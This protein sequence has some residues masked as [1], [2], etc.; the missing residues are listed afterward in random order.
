VRILWQDANRDAFELF[1]LA[2]GAATEPQLQAWGIHGE[3]PGERSPQ[4]LAAWVRSQQIDV[5]VDV[6]G[7]RLGHLLEVLAQRP[8]PVQL[9]G[10]RNPTTT[11]MTTIDGFFSHADI[12]PLNAEPLH[13]EPLLHLGSPHYWEPSD[14]LQNTF[15]TPPPL[16]QNSYLTVGI[17]GDIE[18]INE[19]Y[20]T[21]LT[22][23]QQRLPDSVLLFSHDCFAAP[24]L[25]QWLSHQLQTRQIPASQFRFA[26]LEGLSLAERYQAMDIAVLSFPYPD[27]HEAMSCLYMGVPCLTADTDGTQPVQALLKSV[28]LAQWIAPKLRQLVEHSQGLY[29]LEHLQALRPALR[30]QV[31]A[32]PVMDGARWL[33]NIEGAYRHLWQEWCKNQSGLGF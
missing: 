14:A 3:D 28:G 18:H 2:S 8:A 22:L 7:A 31:V 33:L 26:A 25:A 21:V 29:T 11:G 19:H 32:S 24:G 16:A 15:L 13:R 1:V 6:C 9:S 17:P 4:E 30:A 23:L 20:L 10:L 5:A 12:T 27:L